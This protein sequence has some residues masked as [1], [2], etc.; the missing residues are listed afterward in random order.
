MRQSE[1]SS[2]YDART[3]SA[4]QDT[5]VV[6]RDGRRLA[7][8][9]WGTANGRPVL[10][11][12]GTPGSRLWCPDEAATI[13]ADVRLVNPDRPGIGRSDPKE[14]RTLADWANDVAELA[15]AL[16]IET[17]GVIGYSAGG[18]YAAACAALIPARLTNVAIVSSRG[19]SRYDWEGQ[20]GIESTW[21]DDDRAEFELTRMDPVAAAK[22]AADDFAPFVTDFERDPQVLHEPLEEAEGDR[23]FFADPQRTKT[24]DSFIRECWRQGTAAV[25]WELNT[26][27]LPWGFRL[28]DISIPIGIWHGSQDPWVTDADIEYQVATIPANSLVVWSD[29]GHLGFVKHWGQILAA[30]V[31]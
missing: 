27:F 23:W 1:G 4:R 15:D 25:A 28:A 10:V 7:Y 11:F 16:E 9:E 17:F 21:S 5:S 22:L 8:T 2:R 14:P 24:F 31:S 30:V 13:E 19:L 12:H 29:S 6:L 3:V 20:P 26:I 18:A